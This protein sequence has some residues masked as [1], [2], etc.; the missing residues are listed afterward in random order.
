MTTPVNPFK[1]AIRNQQAQ[2]GLWVSLANPYST[3]I[4]AGAGFDWLLLDGEHAPNDL[5][6]LLA[7]LHTVAGYPKTHAVARVPVG[8]TALIKQYL[9]LGVQTLLVP[10]VDTPEQARA[11][12]QACRYPPDGIRGMA[13]SR[14]SRWGRFPGYVHEANAQVCLLVQVESRLALQN[15]DAII[16]TEGIDGVFI[17]PADLSASLGHVGNA[18]HPEVQTAIEDAIARIVKGGKAAGILTTDTGL[19]KHYMALGTT[20]V[21][22]GL[23][24]QLL[25]RGTNALVG[26]FKSTVASSPVV[27]NSDKTYS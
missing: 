18:A 23:D 2:I 26:E 27:P 25:V 21:A 14:A 16:A 5:R 24:T 17:G 10:M 8:D 6:S 13:G 4:C 20:F 12:V 11:L 7:Q 19:A 9:D 1:Q 22:V 15:L 3:E